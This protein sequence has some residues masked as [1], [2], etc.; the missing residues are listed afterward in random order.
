MLKGNNIPKPIDIQKIINTNKSC[1]FGKLLASNGYIL[2]FEAST[3]CGSSGAPL[4]DMQGNFLGIN[5]GYFDDF[6]EF[7]CINSC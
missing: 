1:S 2:N 6:T 4:V 7:E 3:A 5:T